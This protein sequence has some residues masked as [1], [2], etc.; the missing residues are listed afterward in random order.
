MSLP[1]K[2]QQKQV[3]LTAE[4]AMTMQPVDGLKADVDVV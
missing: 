1:K 2:W 4:S 3:L